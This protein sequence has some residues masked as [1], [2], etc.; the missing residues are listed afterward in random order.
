LIFLI[1]P[2]EEGLVAIVEDASSLRPVSF[3]ESRLKIF[4]VTLE[5]EVVFSEL[6]L[7]LRGQ[8]AKGVILTL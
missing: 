5:E 8:I 2:D 3:E 1:D 7:L 6:L 4:V